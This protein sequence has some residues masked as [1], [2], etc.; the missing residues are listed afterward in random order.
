M[1]LLVLLGSMGAAQAQNIFYEIKLF[2]TPADFAR[3]G[4]K[5]EVSGDVLLNFDPVPRDTL[6]ATLEYSVPLA[7]DMGGDATT[8][9]EAATLVGMAEDEDNNDNGTITVSV[10]GGSIPNLLV[11]NVKLDVSAAS[12][13]ITVTV[14]VKSSDDTDFVRID[15]QNSAMVIEDIKVGVAASAKAETLRTRGTGADGIMLS[16]TLKESFKGA[17]MAGNMVTVDF[18]GIP[19]GVKLGAR[20]TSNPD[21]EDDD[22]DAMPPILAANLPSAMASAVKDG[23]TT[24]T[25]MA[26]TAGDDMATEGRHRY[27][28]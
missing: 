28:P 14:T 17:F 5:G 20:V 7:T 4:G 26:P 22:E 12:G 25:L 16:L 27:R 3:E 2:T 23:S 1:A 15:G 21:P 19:E 10:F 6:T 24:V 11:R 8:S 13:P 18:S 9:I